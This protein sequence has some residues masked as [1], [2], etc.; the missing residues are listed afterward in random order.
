MASARSA[1]EQPSKNLWVTGQA[2][3]VLSTGPGP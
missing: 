1:V 2:L 3:A